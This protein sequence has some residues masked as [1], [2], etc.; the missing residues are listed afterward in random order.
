MRKKGDGR[1]RLKR[2][3]CLKKEERDNVK[4][5]SFYFLGRGNCFF[6]VKFFFKKKILLIWKIVRSSKLMW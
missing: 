4:E 1:L 6:N 2:V 5:N 3:E